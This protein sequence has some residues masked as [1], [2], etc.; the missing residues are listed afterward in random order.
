MKFL[1]KINRQYLLI[2][3]LSLILIS[4]IGYFLLKQIIKHEVYEDIN[5]KELAII[6]EIK[7]QNILINLYPLIE[8][9]KISR[10]NGVSKSSK[11]IFLVDDVEGETEPFLEYTNA[12]NINNQWYQIKLR[13]SLWDRDD[14]IIGIA[15]P[16]LLLLLLTFSFSFFLTKKL[17]K[18]VWRIFE[19]NLIKIENYTFQKVDTLNLENTGIEEFE[20]L[21]KSIMTMTRKLQEDF[22][23]LKEFTENASHEIQTPISIVL[24]NLEEALQQNLSEEAF[25][26][27][28]ASINAIKRLSTLNQSLILLTKIE[29]GQFPAET[30]LIINEIVKQK[31]SEFASLSESKKLKVELKNEGVFELKINEQLLEILINNLFSNAVNHNVNGGRIQIT[32]QENGFVVC[33]TGERNTLTNRTI[34]ERFSKGNSKSYGLGLA[35]VKKICDTHHLDIQYIYSDLHCFTIHLK[36]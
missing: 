7:D 4:L 23:S 18:T 35:I 6:Q 9:K 28:V 5:E 26:H 20:R 27:V 17:N 36:T 1:H 30:N 22:F 34:F 3:V 25:K 10:D 21:N 31:I 12:V 13:H 15:F 29:N 19:E 33:N 32:I 24:L 14:L 2:L 8:T 16:L 11:I